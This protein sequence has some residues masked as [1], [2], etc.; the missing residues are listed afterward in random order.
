MMQ[1][2]PEQEQAI[3]PPYDR[4]LIVVAG[5]GSGKTRVL[6][7]RYMAL[8]EDHPDWPLNALVAIT[9]TRKAAQEMRDRV[10]TELQARLVAA[11]PDERELWANR[12]AAM[13][14]ARI[15]TIHALCGTILRANAAEAGLDPRF[16]VLDEIEA[17][18]LK[19]NVIERVLLELMSGDEPDPVL[20][21]FRHY[22]AA[23]VRRMLMRLIAIPI[24][25]V[26]D[27]AEAVLAQWSQ[28]WQ[29]FVSERLATLKHSHEFV[30]T[31]AWLRGVGAFPPDKLGNLCHDVVD[32]LHVLDQ[33]QPT[34][35]VDTGMAALN[36]LADKINLRAG[37]K[38]A[39]PSEDDFKEAKSVLKSCRDWAKA[40]REQLGDPP[41]EVDKAAAELMPLWFRLIRR[42]QAAYTAIKANDDLLDFDD[43]EIHTQSLLQQD[44]VRARYVNREF[45]H[46]LVDEF[47]DTND[48]QW[49][50]IEALTDPNTDYSE[51]PARLFVVGDPKQSIYGFRGG[52]VRVFEAVRRQLNQQLSATGVPTEIPLVTSFRTHGP[53]INTFNFVFERLLQ[54]D[55]GS[56]AADYE[57]DPGT[58]RDSIYIPFARGERHYTL[59][60]TAGVRRRAR[61][62]GAIEKFSVIKTLQAIDACNVVVLVMD[63][64]QGIGEQDA[65]LAAHVIESGRALVVA[66]NKWDGLD[67]EQRAGIK[68]ALDRKLPFLDFAATHFISA[69]HGSGVGLLLDE[70]DAAYANAMRRLPTPVLTRLL[71][72]AIQ[73]HQPP[74][75][76]G[77]RIKLRYA[78][79]GGRNPPIIVVHGNQTKDLPNTYRRYLI[80]RFREALQLFGTPMRLEFKTGNNP[81]DG[82]TNKLTPRQTKKR[83]RLR[84]FVKRN[85]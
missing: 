81:Y 71:E 9:F 19:Q 77:H 52:D 85:K 37:S 59:I 65:T 38:K 29:V 1:F 54:R 24:P 78:H 80:N 22:D 30:E 73:E 79:Q 76:R 39:W 15:D 61:V 49:A 57:I 25:D 74:L 17:D 13:A 82:R 53:L 55:N 21:L 2:T 69:L 36:N 10:R 48:R 34:A 63:A 70:V 62:S 42:V 20:S 7:Q 56:L 8:L 72:D 33:Y 11:G 46:L 64:Q 50:I 28:D 18:L 12:L 40:V 6:V 32:T 66:V 27:T 83:Q 84:N 67:P 26:P 47:Q 14:S 31:Q 41:G 68:H 51:N 5:A 35:S 44:E 16:R 60:D 3:F 4:N 58:T 45:K 75:V 43:L 23:D